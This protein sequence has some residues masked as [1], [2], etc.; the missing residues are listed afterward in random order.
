VVVPANQA[1]V[2][3][4]FV[5][6]P[7][8]SDPGPYPIPDDAPV[9]GGSDRHVIVV[10][11]AN[12]F[13][14]ELYNAMKVSGGWSASNGA[15][16]NLKTGAPRPMGWTSADAAGLP[17]FP[18]LVRYDE[19]TGAGIKHAIRFT[20]SQSQRGY[21]APASHAAGS[22]AINSA[23][24]PMGMRVRLKKSIDP[25]GFSPQARAIV[26]AMQEYGMIVADN[27][28]NWYFTGAPHPMW[29]DD[30]LHEIDRIR[31]R[32]FE[33]LGVGTVIPQ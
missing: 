28:S 21:I 5:D 29:N 7:E 3:V 32:D 19:A 15:K 13:L 4:T 31:G 20:V 26:V 10:D 24:A 6:W 30:Q 16:W 2:P 27:G 23:C 33:V 11:P 9:E 8:E 17:I 18:G 12:G 22:C 25:A 1:S 14:Y